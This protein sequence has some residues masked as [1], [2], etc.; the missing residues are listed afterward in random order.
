VSGPQTAFLPHR[1]AHNDGIVSVEF[2]LK[3]GE[4]LAPANKCVLEISSEGRYTALYM[5]IVFLA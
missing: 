2:T 1:N 3:A 4:K 5:P